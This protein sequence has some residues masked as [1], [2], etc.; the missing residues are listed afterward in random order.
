MMS[1]NQ[2]QPQSRSPLILIADDDPLARKLLSHLLE[3]LSYHTIEANNGQQCLELFL[4]HQPDIIILDGKM[5]VMDGFTCCQKLRS[6]P[7][8]QHV[9][10]LMITG[11]EDKESISQAFAAGTTDY[12][13]K[14]MNSVVVVHRLQRMYEAS[15]TNT[16]LRISE[17]EHRMLLNSLREVVFKTTPEGKLTFLNTAWVEVTGFTVEESLEKPFF[18][19]IHPLD[20]MRYLNRVIKHSQEHNDCCQYMIRLLRNDQQASWVEILNCPII[21]DDGQYQGISGRLVDITERKQREQYRQ[22]VHTTTRLLSESTDLSLT[23]QRWIQ[24][25]CGYFNWDAGVLWQ[26]NRQQTEFCSVG[27]WHRNIPSLAPFTK[28]AQTHIYKPDL[29]WIKR[30]QSEPESANTMKLLSQAIGFDGEIFG[31]DSSISTPIGTEG[32]LLG[33]ATF[34]S[35]N[36]QSVE[37]EFCKFMDGIGTQFAQFIRRKQVEGDLHRQ[38]ILL[39][40]ELQQAS[41]YVRSL[42]PATMVDRVTIQSQ[43]VPSMQLGGDAFD[44]YWFDD[45]Q[46][47]IY[48]LDVAGHGI[49]SALLSVSIM[50]ILR[51]RA[52]ANTQF[53]SP[54]SVLTALNQFFQ[55]SDTG[56]DYFTLWY[57]VYSYKNRQLTYSSAGHPPALLLRDDVQEMIVQSLQSDG[58]PIGMFPDYDFEE[59]TVQIQPNSHLFV[60]SDGV[61]EVHQPDGVMWG[62]DSLIELLKVHQ[63]KNLGHLS[64]LFQ[65][66]QSVSAHQT[67]DDDFSIVEMQIR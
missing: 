24:L 57:G 55:M 47:V 8:G 43:F 14:P 63:K 62:L 4:E 19:F 12:I 6:L 41:E 10:I 23:I 1:L 5:P 27:V 35:Q 48:L 16:R 33:I 31:T 30:L 45:D 26:L 56:D 52:L 49:K 44:Y 18:D 53:D 17:E 21:S 37:Q 64:D 20:R 60:F 32:Q 28:L 38:N 15:Q 40:S 25:I 34:F 61:Y 59:K 66:I 13:T 7:E 58:I 39:Q 65:E 67:L 50:N 36:I 22:V 2:S 51:S 54:S 42:L 11:L 9:P 46:L 29:D 3:Q